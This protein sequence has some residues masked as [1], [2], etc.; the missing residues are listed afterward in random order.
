L[1][2]AKELRI[3]MHQACESDI[4]L[5]RPPRSRS[6]RVARAVW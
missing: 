4:C 3:A 5:R 6:A 1:C 2:F